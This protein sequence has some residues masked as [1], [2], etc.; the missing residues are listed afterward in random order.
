MGDWLV[1]VG[2]ADCLICGSHRAAAADWSSPARARRRAGFVTIA[3]K[4]QKSRTQFLKSAGL[5]GAALALPAVLAQR[6]RPNILILFT[7]DQRFST[8]NARNNPDV[9][10]PNM[11]RLMRQGTAFTHAF[12]MGGTVPAV[13]MPSRGML[14]TGQTL[15]HV[16]DSLVAPAD[17]PDT[18]KRPYT[19]FPEMLRKA[20]YTTFGTG[21]W[22][23]AESLYPR[24]FTTAQNTSFG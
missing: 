14:M 6:K 11:D 3:P 4:M 12:I 20:G 22:H 1:N 7:D 9:R 8:R 16:H 17:Y 10:T 13:C 19:T 15:F 21:K 23:N 18:P 2:N 24:T 5:G